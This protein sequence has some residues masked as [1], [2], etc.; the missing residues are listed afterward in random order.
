MDTDEEL[1]APDSAPSFFVPHFA[2]VDATKHE[3]LTEQALEMLIQTYS[4]DLGAR[5]QMADASYLE[6]LQSN[7]YEAIDRRL[8]LVQQ[9]VTVNIERFPKENPDI[10]NLVAEL[11]AAGLAMRAAV[12]LCASECSNCRLLCLRAHGHS[13]KHKCGTD[14]RCVFDCELSGALERSEPCGLP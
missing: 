7:I 14:H 13:G 5:F 4:P 9:W 6:A 12:R 8:S 3:T 11:D 10:C 2:G 1:T